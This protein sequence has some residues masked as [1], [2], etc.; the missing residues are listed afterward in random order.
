[1]NGVRRLLAPDGVFV[2][3]VSYL[4]AVLENTL[5]DTIYHEHLDY[6]AV[7]SR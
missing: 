4:G 6:H 3:E 1:M 2:F 5:F 7:D